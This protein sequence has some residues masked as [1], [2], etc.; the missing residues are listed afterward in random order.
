MTFVELRPPPPTHAR[1][2][3]GTPMAGRT[4][5]QQATPITFG[6]KAAGWLDALGR[7]M[8]R[9]SSRRSTGARAC[10][11]AAPPARSRRSAPTGST[12]SSRL[13]ALLDLPVPAVPWH[14]H[15]DRLATLACALGVSCGTLGKIARDVAL[16][17]QTEI[18]EAIEPSADAGGSS[19][20]PHK[21]NPV[22]RRARPVG[23]GP[24]ARPRRDDA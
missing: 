2:H 24:G 10:S 8:R 11:S 13:G 15:R 4:W 3:A 1:L 16:L 9:A 23:G 22:R 12:S 6:L 19:T 17:G 7:T 20:M 21:R 14:A 18:E 5:L